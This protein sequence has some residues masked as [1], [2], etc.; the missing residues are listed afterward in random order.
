M[1]QCVAVCS[2][3]LQCVAVRCSALRCVAVCCGAMQCVAV[4][5]SKWAYRFHILAPP[6]LLIIQR[7]THSRPPTWH[8]SFIRDM[9]DLYVWPDSFMCMDHL[10]VRHDLFM[11][12]TWLIHVCNM[13]RSCV[14][15]DWFI[16]I[17]M[18]I[19]I[20]MSLM[21]M[22]AQTIAIRVSTSIGMSLICMNEYVC[23]HRYVCMH[24][25]L[26]MNKYVYL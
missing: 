4:C 25:Y 10:H 11:Y 13:T 6:P 22:N 16:Y 5:C 12:V 8:D 3:V 23:M 15:H 7:R 26:C 17:R 2:S 19:R 20:G 1:L 24:E 14:W 21:C 18:Q 9:T